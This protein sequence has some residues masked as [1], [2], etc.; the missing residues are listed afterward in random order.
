MSLK[1]PVTQPGI[2]PGTVRLVAQ[3]LKPLRYPRPHKQ[4]RGA[5]KSLARRTSRLF[6]LMVRRF[7]LMLVLLYTQVV[8]IFFQL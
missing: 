7:R 6:C 2:D 4:Y 1:I 3:R 5:D 8:L